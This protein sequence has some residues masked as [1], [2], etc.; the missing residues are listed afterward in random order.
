MKKYFNK[1]NKMLQKIFYVRII[2]TR[3]VHAEIFQFN[4]FLTS[5]IRALVLSACT[6]QFCYPC[7]VVAFV[8]LVGT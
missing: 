8:L 1:Q 2:F 7:F 5:K 3:K 4:I 6:A